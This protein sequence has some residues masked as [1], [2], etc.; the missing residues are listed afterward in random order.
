MEQ[1]ITKCPI[2][3]TGKAKLPTM[4]GD[5]TIFGFLYGK[6]GKEYTMLMKGNVSGKENCPVRLHSECH[7]GD[8]WGSLRCDCRE[9]LEASMRYIS[10][11]PYGI[12][13]YLRQ[14]GRGIGLHN[15]IKAYHL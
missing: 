11:C 2:H 5:F 9:Q 12:I 3:I 10:S 7:T 4:Y 8:V 14:E 13:V 1:P 6:D 15:K